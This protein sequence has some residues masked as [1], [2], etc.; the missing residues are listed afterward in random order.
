MKSKTKPFKEIAINVGS[1]CY[2][3]ETDNVGYLWMPD[4]AYEKGSYG[5]VS[6]DFLRTKTRRRNNIGVDVSVKGSE[7][8]PIYQTQIIGLEAYKFDVPK[9]TYELSLPIA[10]LKS[11]RENAMDISVNGKKVWTNLNLK[12]QYGKDKGVT[13]RFVISVDDE[14]GITI[15]FKPLKG[16][17][18]LSGIKLRK[19]N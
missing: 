5:Y 4:Q 16:K 2:F 17:T 1:L 14:N 3:I 7:N 15:N 13:K 10:E 12:K 8:D 6:G 11:I 18:R 19:V 9:G